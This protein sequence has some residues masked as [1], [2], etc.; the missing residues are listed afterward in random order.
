MRSSGGWHDNATGGDLPLEA[1][2][3]D[4]GGPEDIGG[5]ADEEVAVDG[6]DTG[7]HLFDGRIGVVGAEDA[8]IIDEDGN[9]PEAARRNGI[10]FGEDRRIGLA[11]GGDAAVVAVEPEET[12]REVDS[13]V[14]EPIV[15]SRP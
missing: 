6:V 15:A 11:A 8:H 10:K 3:A 5:D 14:P 12:R 9:G 13:A 1:E 4:G 7:D 2:D